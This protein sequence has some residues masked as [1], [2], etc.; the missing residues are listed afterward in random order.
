MKKIGILVSIA[1]MTLCFLACTQE[2]DTYVIQQSQQTEKTFPVKVTEMTKKRVS[3][4]G[5]EGTLE[6]GFMEGKEDIPYVRLNDNMLQMLQS[7]NITISAYDAAT[8]KFTFT[9]KERNTKAEMDLTKRSLTFENYDLFFQNSNNAYMDLTSCEAFG[10][11]VKIIDAQNIAGGPI[12]LDWSTQDIEVVIWKDGSNYNLAV[13]LQFYNDIFRAVPQTYLLY[14]GKDLY[15]SNRITDEFWTEGNKSGQRS[16]VLA[17]FCYNELCLNLDFNYGLK[18][19]HG[20]D[21]FPDF[22]TYFKYV[23]LKDRLKSLDA[24]TFAGAVKDICEFY[25]GDGHSNYIGNSHYLAKDATVKGIRPTTQRDAYRAEYSKYM[26]ARIGQE[27]NINDEKPKQVPKPAYV[28][29][30]D[31]VIVRFDHFAI[32]DKEKAADKIAHEADFEKPF[33]LDGKVLG[34]LID[35]YVYYNNDKLEDT[36]DTPALIHYVNKLIKAD[37]DIKNVVLDLSCNGGGALYTAAFVISWMLGKCTLQTTNPISGAKWSITYQADVNCDGNYDDGD[38][39]KDKNLFCLV[40]PCSFS[41]G[42]LVPAMLKASDRTTILGVTSGGGTGCVQQSSVADGTLFR[43]SSK[44]I[45]S[46]QKNGSNYD[47]D[48]GVEPHYFINQ[49][50]N[51]YDAAKIAALV[52]SINKAKLSN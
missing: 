10:G 17:E 22:D 4:K 38:T 13:P 49:P 47:I 2:G 39:I 48:K 43:M 44:W 7:Q 1:I 23:G 35:N 45:M 33:T 31:T 29:S 26:S 30:G 27:F 36:Y 34:K 12:K 41:C 15:L 9:N 37:S 51:F 50:E 46:V 16:A 8:N 6:L 52:D 21:K 14:N 24:L 42:N 28:K 25:F 19:I 11:Y 18:A 5:F 3:V 40:S 20:I 32:N